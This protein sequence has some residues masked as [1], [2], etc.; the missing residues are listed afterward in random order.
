MTESQKLR[1]TA[2]QCTQLARTI[3]DERMRS[4]LLAIAAQTVETARAVDRQRWL[5][6]RQQ[7]SAESTASPEPTASPESTASAASGSDQPETSA[8]AAQEA[9]ESGQSEISEAAAQEFVQPETTLAPD[10]EADA[11]EQAQRPT[12]DLLGE[13]IPSEASPPTSVTSES[14]TSDGIGVPEPIDGSGPRLPA[15]GP[16][17]EEEKAGP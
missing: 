5:Q 11:D 2:E 7:A 16:I 17:D 6:S 14:V 15:E 10:V 3:S 13:E 4:A 12:S 1:D 8:T 9:N